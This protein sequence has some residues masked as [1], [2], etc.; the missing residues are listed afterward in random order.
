MNTN[1]NETELDALIVGSTRNN[2]F[3][4]E[5]CLRTHPPTE[6]QLAMKTAKENKTL[7]DDHRKIDFP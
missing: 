3:N 4:D 5:D 2:E 7:K 6:D 1:H